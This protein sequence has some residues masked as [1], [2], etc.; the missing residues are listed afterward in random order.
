MAPGWQA[1]TLVDRRWTAATHGGTERRSWCEVRWTR[2]IPR[3]KKA[4]VAFSTISGGASDVES[5]SGETASAGSSISQLSRSVV[6]VKSDGERRSGARFQIA[7][8]RPRRSSPGR[9][10]CRSRQCWRVLRSAQPVRAAAR[11][12]CW[13]RRR[14]GRE[15]RPARCCAQGAGG[16]LP[17]SRIPDAGSVGPTLPLHVTAAQQS[18]PIPSRSSPAMSRR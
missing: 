10:P 2:S 16:V 3:L 11:R 17:S 6:V 7:V 9:T 5:Q 15:S 1:A 12:S 8:P 13:G 4:C 14:L 18:P